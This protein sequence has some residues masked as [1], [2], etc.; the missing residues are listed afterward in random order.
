MLNSLISNSKQ[1]I[2]ALVYLHPDEQFY[3]REIMRHTEISQGTLHRELKPLVRDGVL[4][5]ETRGNEVFYSVNRNN[6]VYAELR[7]IV[8]KTF[9][10]ADV[11][12]AALKPLRKKIQVTA[13]FG[14]IAT[15]ED[16]S[17]SDIDVSAGYE[18]F[19]SAGTKW[20]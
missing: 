14:S 8:L 2:L 5:A 19:K 11:L 20:N 6:P 1:R 15:G 3:L 7:G 9:G 4:S 12:R 17:R 10:V 16:T 18:I 13:I